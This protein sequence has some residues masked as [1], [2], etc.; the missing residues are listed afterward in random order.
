VGPPVEVATT[1]LG[2]AG[3]PAVV[4]APGEGPSIVWAGRTDDPSAGSAIRARR[5]GSGDG[6]PGP[7]RTLGPVTCLD[8]RLPAAAA[9]PDGKVL[10]VWQVESASTIEGVRIGRS[11][12]QIPT[13]SLAPTVAERW[14][15]RLP[16]EER[17]P[18]ED[19][20]REATR[21]L[22]CFLSEAA[23]ASSMLKGVLANDPSARVR[24][25][26]AASLALVTADA[27]SVL[28]LLLESAGDDSRFVREGAVRGL[29]VLG[30]AEA[31]RPLVELLRND[32]DS[33]VRAAAAA[34]LA[35]IAREPETGPTIAAAIR[36]SLLEA[37]GDRS[38]RVRE[39]VFEALTRLPK[40]P[41]DLANMI[42]EGLYEEDPVSAMDLIAELGPAGSSGAANVRKALEHPEYIVRWRAIRC[43]VKIESGRFSQMLADPEPVVRAQA[44]AGLRYQ[45]RSAL[46][47]SS[48]SIQKAVRLED[49]DWAQNTLDTVWN[50]LQEARCA[51]DWFARLEIQ[52]TSPPV[53]EKPVVAKAPAKDLQT[54]L[55]EYVYI[56]A[57]P[58]GELTVELASD[59]S[60][61]MAAG[62]IGEKDP[63]F[64]VYREDHGDSLLASARKSVLKIK[65]QA[66][67]AAI[68]DAANPGWKERLN[69]RPPQGAKPRA[70]APPKQED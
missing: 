67:L 4:T 42:F 17:Y 31:S 16:T 18:E 41:R 5:M 44:A 58:T 25:A 13:Q 49:D 57:S 51:E 54:R 38:R 63:R 3:R 10:T 30:L 36:E 34:S 9:L 43:L 21:T 23:G 2:L 20:R 37:L 40:P 15:A 12:R 39:A 52:T 68:V 1:S 22:G 27:A 70:A 8:R 35:G 14:Q 55:S 50:A 33:T 46:L 62:E 53:S 48:E 59:A 47:A 45:G 69:R 19:E 24:G 28:P 66:E 56:L 60:R 29:G 7:A 11:G 32:N 26:A 65:S 64:I 6:A 61:M